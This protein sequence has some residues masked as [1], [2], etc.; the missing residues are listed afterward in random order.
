MFVLA[1]GVGAMITLLLQSAPNLPGT[2]EPRS[3][4]KQETPPGRKKRTPLSKRKPLLSP[5]ERKSLLAN[6][7]KSNTSVS[8]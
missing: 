6:R 2:A 4:D 3:L 5:S 1:A 7:A 8:R